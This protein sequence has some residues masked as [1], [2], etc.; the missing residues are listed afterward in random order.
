MLRTR[1]GLIAAAVVSLVAATVPRKWTVKMRGA[2]LGNQFPGELPIRMLLGFAAFSYFLVV[3]LK[4]SG[5]SLQIP[6]VFYMRCA[7]H[8]PSPPAKEAMRKPHKRANAAGRLC[9][10][11]LSRE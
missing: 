4:L 8:A 3:G 9:R 2:D 5:S 6:P 11:L 1:L 10:G 7:P